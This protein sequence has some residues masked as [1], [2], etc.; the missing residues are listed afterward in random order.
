MKKIILEWLKN[1]KKC[2]ITQ[3][4]LDENLL[5]ENYIVKSL[6][7][8]L[9]NNNSL[10]KEGNN[11][12]EE[13]N[14]KIKL[15]E[16][17]INNNNYIEIIENENNIINK[18][19]NKFIFSGLGKYYKNNELIYIGE[20]LNNKINGLGE[21]YKKNKLKWKGNIKMKNNNEINIEGYGVEY[22]KNNLIKY[23]GNFIQSKKNG[24]GI[25]Y[26]KNGKKQYEGQ[27]LDN[28][29]HGHGIQYYYCPKKIN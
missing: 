17:I 23:I 8:K 20:I 1:N 7:I 15:N 14:E 4:Y 10:H 27:F 22:Y 24:T 29:A 28:K 26:M 25:Y 12:V 5:I 3:E 16:I 13:K 21:Y 19:N 2:P 18:I 6:I 11:L 9:K